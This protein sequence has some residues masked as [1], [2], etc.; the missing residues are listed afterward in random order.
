MK[1]K[2]FS[3]SLLTTALCA[4]AQVASAADISVTITNLTNGNHFTP[5]LVSA[6][7][8][9]TH[10][11]QVGSMASANLTAMAE[12]GDIAGLLTDLGGVDADTIEN[13]AAG[14]LA[15]GASTTANLMTMASNTHLTITAMVLPTND[16]FIGMDSMA[17]PTTAGTYSYYLNAY[18]AGTEAND[19]LLPGTDCAAGVAGIPAAPGMNGGMNGTGV[20]GADTNTMIHVHRGVLGDSDD[21]GG[22]SD[23]NNTIHRWQNPVAKV[24]VTVK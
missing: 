5:L 19:E 10:L 12:C 15:P 14:L 11:F 1:L 18:D 2:N 23:L 22:K 20:A 9:N 6:H 21:M 13:P 24:V 16:A 17:L 7:D 8:A 3:K 4:S